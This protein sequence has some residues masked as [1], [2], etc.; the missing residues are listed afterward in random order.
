MLTDSVAKKSAHWLQHQLFRSYLI[1]GWN[2][3]D[4]TSL[5]DRTQLSV[6]YDPAGE[7]DGRSAWFFHNALVC[8][9][10]ISLYVAYIELYIYIHISIQVS[11]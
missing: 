9:Y 11:M 6:A 1:N 8:I 4:G 7:G 3:T 10:L 2:T 5:A